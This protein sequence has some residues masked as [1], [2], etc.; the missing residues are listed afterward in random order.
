M[1]AASAAFTQHTHASSA[2]LFRVENVAEVGTLADRLVKDVG[3]KEICRLARAKTG[4]KGTCV[5]V[6]R[7]KSLLPSLRMP[8]SL[9]VV[10]IKLANFGGNLADLPMLYIH[11]YIE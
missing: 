6:M 7:Q 2:I 1:Y 4:R 3:L 9:L 8:A 11:A 10:V 5:R